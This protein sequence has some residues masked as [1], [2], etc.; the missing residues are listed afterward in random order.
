LYGNNS[1][2]YSYDKEKNSYNFL[3]QIFGEGKTLKEENKN[4]ISAIGF[5]I[6]ISNKINLIA[7]HNPY[8][9]IPLDKNICKNLFDKQYE[10][11]PAFNEQRDWEKY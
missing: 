6:K 1:Y 11:S 5:L 10:I 2:I 7:Y 9:K 3:K 8:A 4:Y